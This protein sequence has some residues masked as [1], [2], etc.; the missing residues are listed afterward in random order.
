MNDLL[1][2]LS[3]PTVNALS[4][5]FTARLGKEPVGTNYQSIVPAGENPVRYDIHYFD[6]DLQGM[7]PTRESVKTF[8]S[9][10]MSCLKDELIRNDISLSPAF[11]LNEGADGYIRVTGNRPDR[12]KIEKIINENPG[13]QLGIHNIRASTSQVSWWES[14]AKFSEHWAKASDHQQRIA[15]LRMHTAFL[16]SSNPMIRISV[17]DGKCLISLNSESI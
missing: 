9:K 13:L 14:A 3:P 1:V 17:S 4:G 16:E 10:V 12:Q 7:I 2:G 5:P 8:G 11:D 6:A 15:L